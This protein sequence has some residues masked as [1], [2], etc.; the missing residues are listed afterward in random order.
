[1]IHAK[2][3]EKNCNLRDATGFRYVVANTILPNPTHQQVTYHEPRVAP[4]DPITDATFAVLDLLLVPSDAA[5]RI[6]GIYS[7]RFSCIASHH[8]A[9]TAILDVHIPPRQLLRHPRRDWAALSD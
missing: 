8:F 6:L 5:H 1:M 7:D 4:L 3:Q 9:V 2:T